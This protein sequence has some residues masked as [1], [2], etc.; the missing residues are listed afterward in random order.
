MASTSNDLARAG[1][2]YLQLH[3]H[4]DGSG[5]E[6]VC[7]DSNTS[8]CDT[9]SKKREREFTWGLLIYADL[10]LCCFK[11][12]RLRVLPQQSFEALSE[13]VLACIV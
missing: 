3:W 5:I 4:E 7:I 1:L 13:L 9:R 8:A 11:V 10:A 6:P 2:G 12:W